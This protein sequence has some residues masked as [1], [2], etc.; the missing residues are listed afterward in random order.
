[1]GDGILRR[2]SATDVLY[3]NL[4]MKMVINVLQSGTKAMT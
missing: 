4:E 3:D 2:N 1:V